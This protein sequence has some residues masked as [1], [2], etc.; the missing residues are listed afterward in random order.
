MEFIIE[1][2]V[3]IDSKQEA[4]ALRSQFFTALRADPDPEMSYRP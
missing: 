2:V 4:E 1:Y 3:K